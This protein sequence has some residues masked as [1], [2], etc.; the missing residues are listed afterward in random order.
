MRGEDLR[1]EVDFDVT[2]EVPGLDLAVFVTTTSGVRVFDEL[3]SDTNA[4]RLP[5]DRYRA[6]LSVPPVLNVGDFSVGVWFGTRHEEFLA[7]PVAA[8]FTLHGSDLQRPERVLVLNL[9][10]S[11]ERLGAVIAPVTRSGPRVPSPRVDS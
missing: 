4:A 8:S 10:F 5:A 11:V 6:S 7:E 3:L 1:I 9:P 2:E